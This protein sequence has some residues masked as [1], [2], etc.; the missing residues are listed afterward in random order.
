MIP[1]STSPSTYEHLTIANQYLH[2]ELPAF[3]AARQ[4]TTKGPFGKWLAAEVLLDA[5]AHREKRAASTLLASAQQNYSGVISQTEGG[6][7]RDGYDHADS[8]VRTH[9]RLTQFKALR[10]VVSRGRMPS[11]GT[12][13]AMYNKLLNRAVSTAEAVRQNHRDRIDSAIRVRGTLGEMAVLLLAQRYALREVGC[14]VWLPLQSFFSEDSGG[15]CLAET[16]TY[17]WDLS[18]FTPNAAARPELTHMLQIKDMNRGEDERGPTLYI[19]PDLALQPT[20]TFVTQAI[21]AACEFE[22]QAPSQAG[23]LTRELDAR[24]E[25]LVELLE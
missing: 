2:E 7:W 6:T 15:D 25:R 3:S 8:R 5:A 18:V 17:A 20:E 22:A 24:T 9:M 19:S 1:R 12:V 14:D 10:D 4:L 13:E 16:N 21:I 23:R 11:P